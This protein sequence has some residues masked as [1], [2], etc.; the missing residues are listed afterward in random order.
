MVKPAL[1]DNPA[2]NLVNPAQSRRPL[3]VNPALR[4]NHQMDNTAPMKWTTR[5]LS[6]GMD[7]K[8]KIISIYSVD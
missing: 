6:V 3:L 5:P 7:S 4:K 8:I 1:V 2:L